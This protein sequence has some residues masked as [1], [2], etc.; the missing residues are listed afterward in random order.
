MGLCNLEK[1]GGAK[2]VKGNFKV[3]EA[4]Y[5]RNVFKF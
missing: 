2:R 4:S 5:E 1:I 3:S